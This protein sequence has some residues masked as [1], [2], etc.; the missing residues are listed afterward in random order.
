MMRDIVPHLDYTCYRVAGLNSNSFHKAPDLVTRL[1]FRWS[2][3]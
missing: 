1:Q 2:G 3:F